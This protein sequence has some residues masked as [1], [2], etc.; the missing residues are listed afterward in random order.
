M[1]LVQFLQRSYHDD[2]IIEAGDTALVSDETVLGE[3]MVAVVPTE[4]EPEPVPM[5][6]PAATVS[7]SIAPAIEA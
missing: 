6:R 3:H 2:R 5:A 1:K 4:P 7:G